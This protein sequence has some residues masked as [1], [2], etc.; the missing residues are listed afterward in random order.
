M[1][2]ASLPIDDTKFQTKFCNLNNL[3]YLRLFMRCEERWESS[4]AAV[5]FIGTFWYFLYKL[6]FIRFLQEIVI[7]RARWIDRASHRTTEGPRGSRPVAALCRACARCDTTT[8]RS[9]LSRLPPTV[10]VL[11]LTTFL[12]TLPPSRGDGQRPMRYH[13]A[14]TMPHANHDT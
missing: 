2:H 8:P 6:R 5:N 13:T 14:L 12:A 3:K 7:A 4:V 10:H 9:H 11:L 1:S